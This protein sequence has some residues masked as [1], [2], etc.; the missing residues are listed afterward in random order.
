MISRRPGQCRWPMTKTLNPKGEV[1]NRSPEQNLK[2]IK[3]EKHSSKHNVN[4]KLLILL[5]L[6][7]ETKR[8][9]K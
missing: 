6:E 8:I 9:E 1:N 4:P 3:S 2:G 7:K 5:E